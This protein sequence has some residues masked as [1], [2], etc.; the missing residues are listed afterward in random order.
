MRTLLALVWALMATPANAQC[1][2]DPGRM[3]FSLS[4]DAQAARDTLFMR[5]CNSANGKLIDSTDPTVVGR[6]DDPHHLQVPNEYPQ[7]PEH[8]KGNVLLAIIVDTEGWVREVTVLES[9]SH[10]SLDESALKFWRHLKFKTPG[11]LDGQPVRTLIYYR[12]QF[13]VKVVHRTI[14][15]GARDA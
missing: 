7:N 10:K 6:L 13:T 15:E 9:S 5:L 3:K 1:V 14:V 11:T 8:L 2:V 4:A 12:M